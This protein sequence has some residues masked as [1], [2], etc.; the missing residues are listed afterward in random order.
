N[1]PVVLAAL[2][3]ARHGVPADR[4]TGHAPRLDV[5]GALLVTAGATLLVLGLVRTE[6]HGWTSGT[7]LGTLAAAAVLL[8]A[9]V[10]VEARKREPLLRLGLLGPA[11]RPVLSANVFAL[12]MS[13]GQ[14]A[15]FYFTSLHLQQV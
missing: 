10:A 7:T 15:A 2:L 8:A 14:F 9:F 1:V 4:R 12:L 13:S 11:H 5:T 3:A 6:T